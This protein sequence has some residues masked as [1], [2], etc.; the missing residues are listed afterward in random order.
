M[1]PSGSSVHGILQ[2]RILGWAAISCSRGSSQPR[3]R[4][5]GSCTLAGGYFTLSHL[6]S[7]HQ[8]ADKLF[9]LKLPE[10]TSLLQIT[11][12][13]APCRLLLPRRDPQGRD[14]QGRSLTPGPPCIPACRAIS[15]PPW[16]HLHA[17]GQLPGSNSQSWGL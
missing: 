11:Y 5:C 1:D 3:D 16:L 14:P 8:I 4:T 7:P 15:T 13:A 2:A 6:G 9:F 12:L 10:A 17:W